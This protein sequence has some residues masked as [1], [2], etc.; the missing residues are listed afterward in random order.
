MLSDI[1]SWFT[2]AECLA[3]TIIVWRILALTKARGIA[4]LLAAFAW[5]IVVRAGI[6]L[7]APFLD[8]HSRELTT[9]TFALFA[10]GL[11]LLLRVLQQ[12]YKVNGS[13]NQIESAASIAAATEAARLA[14]VHAQEAALAAEIA[15]RHAQKAAMLAD[16]AAVR[17]RVSAKVAGAAGETARRAGEE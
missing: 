9:I 6:S 4:V 8:S 3:A 13:N 16:Q 10:V 12:A 1:L 5:S 17:A 14:K 2:L 11:Y 15:E 7:N